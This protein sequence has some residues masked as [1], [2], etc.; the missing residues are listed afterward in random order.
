MVG[1]LSIDKSNG[2]EKTNAEVFKF[3]LVAL[4]KLLAQLFTPIFLHK[5]LRLELMK[6]LKCEPSNI[7]NIIKADGAGHQAQD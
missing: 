5:F 1:R 6:V 7:G 2:Y 3:G 4:I